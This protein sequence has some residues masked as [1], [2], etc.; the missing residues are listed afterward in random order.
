[1]NAE[2][3]RGTR[4][5]RVVDLMPGEEMEHAMGIPVDPD[6]NR[7]TH[8]VIGCAMQ[9]HSELGS[10][11]AERVYEDAMEYELRREGL[12]FG[13]QVETPVRYKDV[14]LSTQ[15]IDRVV[16]DLIVVE[17]KAVEAV[18]DAHLAQ[19]VNYLRAADLPLGLLINFNVRS[20]KEGIFRRINDAA[21]ARRR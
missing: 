12:R 13:R 11:F 7:I 9:V 20:L 5:G 3:R 15:R 18:P 6:W 14:L 2:E 4:R 16:E 10:G 17:L 21:T 8:R 19:L 1:M